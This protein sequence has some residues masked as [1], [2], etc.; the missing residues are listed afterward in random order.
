[1]TIRGLSFLAVLLLLPH[2]AHADDFRNVSTYARVEGTIYQEA[3]DHSQSEI[4]IGSV[5][6][7]RNL[8]VRDIHIRAIVK[9]DID[10]RSK[11]ADTR[12]NIGSVH[13]KK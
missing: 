8:P 1:M 3:L 12:L 10:L 9:G 7:E 11:G 13:L 6:S 5:L 4:N 2:I